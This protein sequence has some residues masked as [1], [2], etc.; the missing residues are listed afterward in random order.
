MLFCKSVQNLSTEVALDLALFSATGTR[1]ED[2]ERMCES[3]LPGADSND[4]SDVDAPSEAHGSS[5]AEAPVLKADECGAAAELDASNPSMVVPGLADE[6]SMRQSA[7]GCEAPL[8]LGD[9]STLLPEEEVLSPV[10]GKRR[11]ESGEHELAGKRS[12]HDAPTAAAPTGALVFTAP[13]G[14]KISVP[15]KT[16]MKQVVYLVCVA[17]VVWSG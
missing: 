10:L 4:D 2:D 13:D 9:V 17:A 5:R 11:E 15:K 14:T 12:R 7:D 1:M 16:A 3:P 8:A 6:V